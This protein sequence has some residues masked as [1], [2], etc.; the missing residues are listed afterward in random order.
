MLRK[1]EVRVN[2]KRAKPQSRLLQD[3]QVRV[4]PVSVPDRSEKPVPSKFLIERVEQSILFEDDN[5]I[6][7]NKPAG[8]TVHG[9]TNTPLG[10]IE[11]LKHSRGEEH[12]LE[13]AHRLDR[14]TSGCL[15]LAKQADVL[16]DIHQQLLA[17]ETDKHYLALLKGRLKKSPVRIEQALRKNTLKGGERIVRIDP[18]GK[19]AISEFLL[20]Q[21]FKE[22][23]L[24]E[25]KIETGRTHQIRV[26]AQ[27]IGNPLAMD[28]KY[29]DKNFNNSMKVMGL[30]RIFLHAEQVKIK[31]ACYPEAVLFRAP[32][33]NELQEFIARL[34]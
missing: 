19:L 17:R 2:G 30:K 6:V 22:C 24:A 13:L 25:V 5:L 31:L 7:L 18:D 9:G 26:H 10:I 14:D 28:E 27:H 29:G 12:Y 23:C 20:K 16:K 21:Q 33:P 15:M 32:I 4:P 8:I 11:S 3:D 1:G 34:N